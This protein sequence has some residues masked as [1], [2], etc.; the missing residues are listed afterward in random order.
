MNQAQVPPLS[1][2]MLVE[3]SVKYTIGPNPRGGVVCIQGVRE[4]GCIK[5]EVRDGGPGFELESAPA[6]HGIDNLRSR[7]AVLFGPQAALSVAKRE[8]GS[9]VILSIPQ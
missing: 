6:G 3:N 9:A 8:N 4:N 2:Q 1:I 7:L 5:V